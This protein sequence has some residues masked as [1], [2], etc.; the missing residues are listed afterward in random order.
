MTIFRGVVGGGGGLMLLVGGGTRFLGRGGG[1]C[2]RWCE[3]GVVC[4]EGGQGGEGMC[5]VF[6]GGKMES[7][8]V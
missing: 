6:G 2:M 8:G 1:I 7:S 5:G 3:N 4:S